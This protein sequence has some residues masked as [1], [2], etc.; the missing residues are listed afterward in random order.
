MATIVQ[1][2]LK[3][4]G[5]TDASQHW[6]AF[7][8]RRRLLPASPLVICMVVPRPYQLKSFAVQKAENMEAS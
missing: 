7:F 6:R 8:Q 4:V 1:K 3:L 2:E 5:T